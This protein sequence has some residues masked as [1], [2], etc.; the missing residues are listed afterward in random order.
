[1]ADP[2]AGLRGPAAAPGRQGGECSSAWRREPPPAST[3]PDGM[4]A[5]NIT[6]FNAAATGHTP[7]A[8]SS[9][10]AAEAIRADPAS[11]LAQLHAEL[12]VSDRRVVADAG[13]RAGLVAAYA[14]ALRNST[15]GWIDDILAL[16]SHWGFELSTVS[17]TGIALA[18][19]RRRVLPGEPHPVA[20]PADFH[21]PTRGSGRSRA[22]RCA[23]RVTR[24]PQVARQRAV[25]VLTTLI[26]VGCGS[27]SLLLYRHSCSLIVSG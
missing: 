21:G 24:G 3:G 12:P 11:L 20:R 9:N 2:R 25:A 6:S 13:I 14:D 22:L 4:A 23:R 27:R 26:Y 10:P 5:S 17:G 8:A 18:R 19:R 7:A 15:Y 16:C 1:M